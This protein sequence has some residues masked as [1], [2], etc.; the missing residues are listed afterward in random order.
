MLP[1]LI[2]RTDRYFSLLLF[3]IAAFWAALPFVPRR[4]PVGS[5][6]ANPIWVLLAAL[7]FLLVFP[8]LW[9]AQQYPLLMV[10]P[11][12]AI[13]SATLIVMLL[14]GPQRIY[15]GVGIALLMA[16]TANALYEGARFQRAFFDRDAIRTLRVQLDSLAQ[17]GQQVLANH[18]FD[19]AYR[20]YFDRNIVP[21]IGH[22]SADYAGA[23]RFFSDPI[24][25]QY[26]SANGALLV[27]HKH[28]AD[29]LFDKG[30]Y[31]ILAPYHFW[32]AW[33]NPS[34]YRRFLDS[35]IVTRDSVLTSEAA[36]VGEKV[37]ESDFYVLWR[38]P[39]SGHP[40]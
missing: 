11:F 14:D 12:Y 25:P 13:G 5:R 9:V 6:L 38:I 30:Y 16:I 35:L 24:R 39:P 23:L 28:V 3:P 4:A 27:Q 10:V 34:A 18:V 29:E 32:S 40:R 15:K 22:P 31:Y 19:H 33:A 2:G 7:P 37:Y 1:V 26:A 17:P 21:M 36:R 20:Y 8:E